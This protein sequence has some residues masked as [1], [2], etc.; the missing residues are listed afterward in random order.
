MTA[1]A[2]KLS[3]FPRGP[4]IWVVPA[5][6]LAVA[7]WMIVREWSSHGTEITIEFADGAGVDTRQTKLEYKGVVVGEVK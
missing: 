6:A 4:L 3:R 2:P 7:V 1:P 5:V